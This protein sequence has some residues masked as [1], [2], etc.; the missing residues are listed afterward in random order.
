[1]A[2]LKTSGRS[3]SS[4]PRRSAAP[5]KDGNSAAI[6]IIG[7]VL[8][9]AG[10]VGAIVISSGHGKKAAA[11]QQWKSAEYAVLRDSVPAQNEALRLKTNEIETAINASVAAQQAVIQKI[12]QGKQEVA[13]LE[14]AWEPLGPEESKLQ[15]DL[16]AAQKVQ[17]SK[18]ADS[19]ETV[20][21]LKKLADERKKYAQYY[22]ASLNKIEDSVRERMEKG[23]QAL[24]ALAGQI[25]HTPFGP[26]AL[27]KTAELYYSEGNRET[28][29]NL[30]KQ[31]IR[32]YPNSQYV[33]AATSQA[34]A[35]ASGHPYSASSAGLKPEGA[36]KMR[37]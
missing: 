10:I 21:I 18:G 33:G 9:V 14:K 25:K 31:V 30:Y 35:A 4:R 15:A 13:A 22:I 5:K 24:K 19:K 36:L 34:S 37:R 27:F 20:A 17:S 11:I 2:K 8:A 12:A 6:G 23:P 1:M 32:T 16:D 28:A 29:A 26:A 7:A 3:N